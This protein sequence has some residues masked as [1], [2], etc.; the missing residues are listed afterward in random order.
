MSFPGTFDSH[1]VDL[2]VAKYW[3]DSLDGDRT[4]L[5]DLADF[6]EPFQFTRNLQS[7]A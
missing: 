7:Q 2:L 1:E 3:D 5:K 6:I 4:N